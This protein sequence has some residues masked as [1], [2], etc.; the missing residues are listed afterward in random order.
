MHETVISVVGLVFNIYSLKHDEDQVNTLNLKN[1]SYHRTKSQ[2]TMVRIE[3]LK[4][5]H[6]KIEI[7]DIENLT[8]AFVEN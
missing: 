8:L 7:K 3:V 5:W 2:E 4:N 6:S 1:T